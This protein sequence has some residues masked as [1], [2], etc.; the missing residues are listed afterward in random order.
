M[1]AATLAYRND[2]EK[3]LAPISP[4]QPAGESLTYEGTYDRIQAARREDDPRLS[5]GIYTTELKRANWEEAE[6]I[7]LDALSTRSKD[8][9]LAAWF[10]EAAVHRR[11]FSGV[12]EGLRLIT[13]LCENFWEVLYPKLQ[14]DSLED[15][16]APFEWINN[17]LSLKLKQ[18]PITAPS[19]TDVAI[20]SLVD[21]ES[22][23]HLANLAN[24]TPG[25]TVA[26]GRSKL[27][28]FQTSVMATETSFYSAVLSDV[29][30]SLD[31][32]LDLERRL[33]ESCGKD[34]PSL[35]QFEE[36][37]TS[38]QRLVSEILHSRREGP[39]STADD[40]EPYLEAMDQSEETGPPSFGAISSRMQAYRMLSEAAD[41]L[42]RTEPHSPVPYLVQRAVDWG[43][44]NLFQV[45][46]QIVRNE[47][48]LEEIDKLL[49][50]SKREGG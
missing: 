40:Q 46:E 26:D 19:R 16:I 12:G 4:E 30:A 25:L 45:L 3:L 6:R 11:G 32:C 37:L 50:L 22:A 10:L 1:S 13:S 7:C 29:E 49:R 9:R 24:K 44:M 39:I 38:V 5:Q 41:Y 20:C 31:A 15:R 23:C 2:L 18:I 43:N 8:L 47:T 34:S 35:H 42:L 48:E 28:A 21:W 14:G 36:S 17:K 33:D 27:A